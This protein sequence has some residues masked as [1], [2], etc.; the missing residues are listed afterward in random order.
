MTSCRP[1]IDWAEVYNFSLVAP[2]KIA[3]HSVLRYRLELCGSYWI[4]FSD[5]HAIA[6]C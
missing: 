3:V 2:E 4:N 5:G 1:W 6:R